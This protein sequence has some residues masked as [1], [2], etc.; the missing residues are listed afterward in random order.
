MKVSWVM[1]VLQI[2]Q[3]MD[4]RMSMALVTNETRKVTTIRDIHHVR[5][6]PQI[7]W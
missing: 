3:A 1:G 5:K 2:I 4:D 7:H 6:S